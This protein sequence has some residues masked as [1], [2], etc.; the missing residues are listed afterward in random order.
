MA[1]STHLATKDGLI[2]YIIF[3]YTL[4][5]TFFNYVLDS[6]FAITLSVNALLP[7]LFLLGLLRHRDQI[8][9]PAPSYLLSLFFLFISLCVGGFIATG[10]LLPTM[11]QNASLV[12]AFLVGYACLR[13]C[14]NENKFFLMFAAVSMLYTATC[15]IAVLEIAPAVFPVKGD[16]KMLGRE[17]VFRYEITTDQNF[18]IL[19]FIGSTT[20]LLAVRRLSHFV[21]LLFF[22]GLNFFVLSEIQTRS[23]FLILILAIS[24]VAFVRIRRLESFRGL[25][26]SLAG[27]ALLSLLFIFT[28]PLL[29][30]V[31]ENI[32]LRFTES[33]FD[34]LDTRTEAVVVFFRILF[35]PLRWLPLEPNFFRN[36]YGYLP[37]FS[38]AVL[39]LQGGIF[40]VASWLYV[41]LV[42]VTV[43]LTQTLVRPPHSKLFEVVAVTAIASLIVYMS[44]PIHAWDVV[45]LWSGAS[46]G[47]IVREKEQRSAKVR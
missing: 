3:A 28:G 41:Q 32:I 14:E 31:F 1:R 29:G 36:S 23:G 25:L 21:I 13:N 4:L 9:L 46:V 26:Y 33:D 8:N 10:E 19:Y 39:I 24:M 35:D 17:L 18:Q 34:T 16:L 15:T 44:A 11:K 30:E 42:P 27:L 45:W 12:V 38:P 20:L 47:C 22:T 2:F 5:D 43:N 37:H 40:A 6:I 7:I